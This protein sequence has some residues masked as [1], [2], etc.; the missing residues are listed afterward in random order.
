MVATTLDLPV[1]SIDEYLKNPNSEEAKIE[2]KK[3]EHAVK[4]YSAFAIKDTRVTEQQNSEF[5]DMM[6]DYFDQE[7]ELKLEDSRP[8]LHYQVGATPGLTELP[9]CGRD[10]DCIELVSKMLDENKPFEFDSPDPKWRFFWRLGNPPK[11]TKFKQVI[12]F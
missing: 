1:I 5:L 4:T 7:T 3:M 8:E 10:D 12:Y 11:E 2:I 9:R 6:E